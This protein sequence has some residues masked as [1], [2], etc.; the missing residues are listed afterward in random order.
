M[1]ITTHQLIGQLLIE[2]GKIEQDQLNSA[3]LS[4]E[5]RSEQLGEILKEEGAISKKEFLE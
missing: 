3:L 4:Q 5:D 1:A 2:A